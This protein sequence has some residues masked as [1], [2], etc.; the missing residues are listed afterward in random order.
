MILRYRIDDIQ[1]LLWPH[2][3]SARLRV[4]DVRH[5]R[6]HAPQPLRPVDAQLVALALEPACAAV[7]PAPVDAPPA[8]AHRVAVA[9]VP[10]VGRAPDVEVP[11]AAPCAVVPLPALEL[12]LGP[13]VA[14]GHLDAHPGPFLALDLAD[15]ACV[16]AEPR[17]LRR[18]DARDADFECGA[19]WRAELLLRRA[20]RR[21]VGDRVG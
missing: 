8:H 17:P 20:Q 21:L 5:R 2:K 1:H 3:Q 13:V 10:R 6:R 15:V 4:R 19:A 11:D 7:V 16:R 9:V 18:D 14:D 12:L